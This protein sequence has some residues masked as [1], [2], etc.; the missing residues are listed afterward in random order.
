MVQQYSAFICYVS[1]WYFKN[2]LSFSFCIEIWISHCTSVIREFF[3]HIIL[4][5][6]AKYWLISAIFLFC[7]AQG[8]LSYHVMMHF[9]LVSSFKQ[10]VCYITQIK[11][12]HMIVKQPSKKLMPCIISI[13]AFCFNEIK[14]KMQARIF[15]YHKTT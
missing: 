8:S 10:N 11:R 14:K 13:R 7:S 4:H 6:S 1:E 12:V 3:N 9:L 5:N 15:F 2:K